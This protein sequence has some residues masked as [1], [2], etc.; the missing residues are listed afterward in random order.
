[1]GAV[2]LLGHDQ[3]VQTQAVC[4]KGGLAVGDDPSLVFS[5]AE[6]EVAFFGLVNAMIESGLG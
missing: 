5:L 1:M 2:G 4:L 6:A 3:L